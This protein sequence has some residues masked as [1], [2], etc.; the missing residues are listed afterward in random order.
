MPGRP[1]DD[2][3]ADS[4]RDT[5]WQQQF[6][7]PQPLELGRERLAA[8]RLEHAEAAGAEIEPGEAESF[9]V[10][11]YRG[12]QVV[13]LRVEERV[14]G[15]GPGRHDAHDLA[16]DR[17]LALADLA[18]LLADR[19]GLALPDEAREIAVELVHGNARH[20]NGRAV[21]F[22]SLR[23]DDVEKPR[24]AARVVVEE[25]VEIPH[26]IE[27]EDVRMLGLDAQILLHHRRVHLDAFE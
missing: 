16:R 12:E 8:F 24:A 20:R 5:F 13:P 23:Q 25:L 10:R 26:A 21:G 15:H 17:P 19:D 9:P 4:D 2:P 3:R 1:L 7:G 22:T 18:G 27:Q 6:R 11:A 14:V